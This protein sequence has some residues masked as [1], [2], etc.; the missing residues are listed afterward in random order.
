MFF[1]HSHYLVGVL[2]VSHQGDTVIMLQSFGLGTSHIYVYA[3]STPCLK[4][5]Y[6]TCNKPFFICQNLGD[7]IVVF[8]GFDR[9]RGIPNVLV[10]QATAIEHFCWPNGLASFRH[11]TANQISQN[12][13]AES[14]HWSQ[15]KRKINQFVERS[16]FV[17]FQPIPRLMIFSM[18]FG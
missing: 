16:Y 8:N 10:N 11:V 5:R 3:R 1:C 17:S 6:G 18:S 13:M 9:L 4:L 14:D 7:Q 15:T 12:D 2:R